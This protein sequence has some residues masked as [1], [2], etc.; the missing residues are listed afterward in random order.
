LITQ[1]NTNKDQNQTQTIKLGIDMNQQKT[2]HRFQLSPV[3]FVRREGDSVQIAILPEY[4]SAL[5]EL[6]TFSHAQILWWFSEFDDES[7][8]KTTQF[9]HMPFEAPPLGVFACRSPLRPNPIGLSTVKILA[10][11]H[12]L[13]LL[14]IADMDAYDGTPILDI[15]AYMPHCDRVQNVKVPE[16][17]ADWP[18]W[19]PENGLGL[20]EE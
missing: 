9:D 14:I 16:W 4:Q 17:A 15:K 8:R 10:V 2:A 7:S 19:M 20:E 5:K 12:E 1:F 6:P 11:D 13:G 18:D 3:G